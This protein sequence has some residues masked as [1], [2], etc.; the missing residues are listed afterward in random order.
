[1]ST[2]IEITE[3]PAAAL[4]AYGDVPI[5]FTVRAVLAVEPVEGGLGGLR[6]TERAVGRP[7]VKDYDADPAHRP[8]AWPATLDVSRW[9]FLAAYAA[10]ETGDGARRADR[11][12]RE[13][14]GGAAV[15]WQT[16]GLAMTQGRPDL[17]VLWDVR[18][19]PAWRGR[20]AGTTLFGAAARWAAAR[21]A[22]HLAIKTQNVNVAA[23]RF[24]AR[25]GCTLGAVHRLAYPEAPDEAQLLWYLTLHPHE[26]AA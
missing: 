9:G 20:G 11:P 18:V 19:A 5:A 7:Y 10:T 15:A 26:R 24:Y 13:R 14:V 3:E 2:P 25:Q 12:R 21:G 4:A 8:P 23:C 6:L 1:M 16:P 22:R 17:A